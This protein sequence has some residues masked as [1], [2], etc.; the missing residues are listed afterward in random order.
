RKAERLAAEQE[1]T[2]S[3]TAAPHQLPT[4]ADKNATIEAAKTRAAARKAERLA[5][6]QENTSSDTAAPHQLP[7]DADKNATI[8]AAKTRAAARK[9]ERLAAEQKN[10][11]I[12]D[13]NSAPNE[14]IPAIISHQQ[15]STVTAPLTLEELHN[16]LI[17]KEPIMST[18]DERKTRLAAARAKTAER[19]I[20][21]AKL[22]QHMRDT[23]IPIRKPDDGNT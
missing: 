2:S 18:D 10:T 6:E 4:D 16:P 1:N 13:S 11:A 22:K 9:A 17:E 7:T 20:A 8:E 14:S 21:H 19:R 15:N 12:D 3:D 23:A 5:A